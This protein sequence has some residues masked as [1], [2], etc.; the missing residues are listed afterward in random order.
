MDALCAHRWPLATEE[1]KKILDGAVFQA[2]GDPWVW[3]KTIKQIL[4]FLR[5]FRF[6]LRHKFKHFETLI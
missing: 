5:Q 4:G 1:S 2:G 3:G 6:L